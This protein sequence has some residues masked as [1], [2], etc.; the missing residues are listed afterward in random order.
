[1]SLTERLRKRTEENIIKMEQ[2]LEDKKTKNKQ[3]KELAKKK[4]ALNSRFKLKQDADEK[5]RK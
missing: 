4:W 1:M 5:S 2:E 3:K